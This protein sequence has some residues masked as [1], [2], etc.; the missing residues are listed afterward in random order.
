MEE[1]CPSL[2]I[3]LSGIRS[4]RSKK[5][6][7]LVDSLSNRVTSKAAVQFQNSQS[8]T[9]VEEIITVIES[10]QPPETMIRDA[11]HWALLASSERVWKGLESF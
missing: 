3:G 8:K 7:S 4:N 6:T 10:K 11:F 2:R 1:E 5:V 9:A